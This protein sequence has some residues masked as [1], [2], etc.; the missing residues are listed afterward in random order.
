MAC[1]KRN[2]LRRE[3]NELNNVPLGPLSQV[4][5]EYKADG[6][7]IASYTYADDLV[8]MTRSSESF[9]YHFDGLGSTRQLTD[10]SAAV[11]DTFDYDAFG[12]LIARTGVTENTFLFAGQTLDASIAFLHLRARYYQPEVGRFTSVDSYAGEANS[13]VTF[14]KY[15]YA[16]NDPLDMV[17]PRGTEFELNSI[18]TSMAISGTLNTIVSYNPGQTLG[19]VASNFSVGAMEGAAFYGVGATAI[20]T[21]IKFGRFIRLEKVGGSIAKYWSKLLAPSGAIPGTS[22]PE[23]FVFNTRAGK[24]FVSSGGGRGALK[25]IVEYLA[26]SGSAADT[27][28]AET[29]ALQELEEAIVLAEMEGIK[30]MEKMIVETSFAKWELMFDTVV[31]TG[32][33]P[34]LFHALFFPH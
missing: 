15:L 10:S 5:A 13:P 19:Q 8:S 7:V 25:H 9:Y 2:P 34:K 31:E 33:Y 20:K 17:D 18:A 23:F 4:S 22:L 3:L 12:N 11:T 16:G 24:Y 28:L 1:L 21:F 26:K 14:H 32:K 27:K 29:L 6:T 30:N